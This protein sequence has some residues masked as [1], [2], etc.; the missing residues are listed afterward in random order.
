MRRIVF[1]V[2]AL[3]VLAFTV[4]QLVAQQGEGVTNPVM[5]VVDSEPLTGQELGLDDSISLYFDHLLDCTTIGSAFS[6]TPS[7]AGD[8]AC[9]GASLTFTPDN[10]FERASTYRITI[11]DQLRSA[12]GA[13][14]LESYFLE[15]NTVGF[16]AV[17]ETFPAPDASGVLTDTPITVIFNRPVVPLL[18]HEERDTLPQPLTIEPAVEGTGSWV[19]TSIYVFTPDE[20]LMGGTTY[21]VRVGGL[22]AADGS[23]MP[24]DYVFTFETEPP[25][26]TQYQPGD[27]DTELQLNT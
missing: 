12:E 17:S 19:N 21:T 23:V 1:F 22:E 2:A 27:G 6:I 11:N 9:D 4:P 10:E 5:Q 7:I 24:D 20:P 18:I 14:L 13:A 15:L 26:I 3:V 25:Q 16:L 8:L